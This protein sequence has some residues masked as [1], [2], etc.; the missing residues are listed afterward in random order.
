[1]DSCAQRVLSIK[2]SSR[3][4]PT[5]AYVRSNNRWIWLKSV[6]FTKK[7]RDARL[8][9]DSATDRRA[10]SVRAGRLETDRQDLR[11]RHSVRS[12]EPPHAMKPAGSSSGRLVR[13][14]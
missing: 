10:D 13:K 8:R 11:T 5:C 6:S 7:A 14:T 12:G 3:L 1:M 9:P 4:M 2:Q